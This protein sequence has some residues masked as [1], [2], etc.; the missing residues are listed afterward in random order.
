[1][2]LVKIKYGYMILVHIHDLLLKKTGAL[3]KGTMPKW[4]Q[5]GIT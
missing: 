4:I 1:M 3:F 5:R 2:L